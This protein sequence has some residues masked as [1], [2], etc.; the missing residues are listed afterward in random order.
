MDPKTGYTNPILLSDPNLVNILEVRRERGVE[1][2]Q[3]GDFRWEGLLR[4]NE[5]K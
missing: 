1:L 4:W 2:A 3:E 5:G